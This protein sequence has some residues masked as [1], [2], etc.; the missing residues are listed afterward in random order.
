VGNLHQG[1]SVAEA[2]RR[3]G[4]RLSME[5]GGT[6]P[7]Q[8]QNQAAGNNPEAPKETSLG[9]DFDNLPP[10]AKAL[11]QLHRSSH[12]HASSSSLRN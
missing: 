6:E 1:I 2:E 10:M 12:F 11:S 4:T 5:A 7:A 3:A 8:E 9:F